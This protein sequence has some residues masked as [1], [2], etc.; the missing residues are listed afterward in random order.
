M[1]IGRP[2]PECTLCRVMLSEPIQDDQ[3]R[4]DCKQ[5]KKIAGAS[6]QQIAKLEAYNKLYEE[7]NVKWRINYGIKKELL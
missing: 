7:K 5:L 3:L 1:T 2:E 4:R 6:R